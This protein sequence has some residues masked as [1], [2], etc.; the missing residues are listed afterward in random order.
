MSV[1]LTDAQTLLAFKAGRSFRR[2]G[3][4][5]VD[6]S[7]TKGAVMLSNAE[8]GLLHFVWKERATGEVGED[9]ILLP[10][11]ATFE[12]VSQAGPHARTYVLK[13]ESSN[14]RHFFWMQ[15]ASSR[16]DDEFVFN[17]N[18]LLADPSIVPVW[19]SRDHGSEPQA[20]TSASTSTSTPTP[21]PTGG[22]STTSSAPVQSTQRATQPATTPAVTP[23]QLER[24]RALVTSMGASTD[25]NP[26]EDISLTDIVTPGHIGSLVA[27]NPAL[28]TTLFPHLP[29]DLIPEY[30][31][32]APLTSEERRRRLDILQRTVHS[33]QFR[34]AVVQL[35]RA[36]RTGALG[37]FV[38]SLGL[39][40]SAGTGVNAFLRA[41]LLRARQ[42]G[43]VGAG[44]SDNAGGA[45]GQSEGGNGGSSG[46]QGDR[47]DED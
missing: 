46:E 3:T 33:P 5:F 17:L 34:A 4:N 16:R 37:G 29:P 25:P 12:K 15:D 24:L 38:R 26:D 27:A 44:T 18:R 20:S 32:N 47:M 28:L 14:Q 31:V 23:E 39:P 19:D 21:A 7:P 43:A 11:D 22:A 8:D 40:E 45:G 2:A 36:L 6:A 13:F 30:D 41:I 35:D 10:G 1:A 9:L 42:S